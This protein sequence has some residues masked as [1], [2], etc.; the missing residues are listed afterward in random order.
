MARIKII[1]ILPIFKIG[2]MEDIDN[3]RLIAIV[4]VIEKIF[5]II[6]KVNLVSYAENKALSNMSQYGF[7]KN[8]STLKTVTTLMMQLKALMS[9]YAHL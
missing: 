7:R 6:L 9:A 8:K 3:Y 2:D 5:K 4:P 1:K